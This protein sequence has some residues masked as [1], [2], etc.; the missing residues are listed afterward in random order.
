MLE[1]EYIGCID[2]SNKN[3]AIIVSRIMSATSIHKFEPNWQITIVRA[4]FPGSE[5]N[6]I[7][8]AETGYDDLSVL[9]KKDEVSSV[10]TELNAVINYLQDFPYDE[11]AI[12]NHDW[13]K[14]YNLFHEGS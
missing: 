7:N 1:L 9:D 3:L 10:P 8:N 11:E 14:M 5:R 12:A 2:M 13:N 6:V 4:S